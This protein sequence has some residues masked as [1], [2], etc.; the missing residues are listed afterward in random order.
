MNTTLFSTGNRKV[1]KDTLI[2]NMNSAMDCPADKLGLC[3]ISDKC[4]A[5]K[6]ERQY[7]AVLP[8]RRRQAK[9]WG[10]V[11]PKGFVK[12]FMELAD[13]R[14]KG[15][16][17][18]YFR[19]SESGDFK[20]QKDVNKMV[21]IAKLLKEESIITY[22]Y[23]AR[24]DLDFKE[25]SKYAVVQGSGFMVNNQFVPVKEF[26]GGKPRCV[27]NC[28]DCRLCKISMGKQIQVIEH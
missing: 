14:R 24:R 15:N 10:N 8:Y 9:S 27:G 19:F 13:K 22:G 17:V 1:G 7:P 21:E 6:A 2:F 25:L 4:Y 11:T 16:E 3:D 28:R 26:E 20:S 5:K 23:T 12:A 18:R